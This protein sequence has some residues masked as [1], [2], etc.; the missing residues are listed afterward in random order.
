MEVHQKLIGLHF[1]LAH[2]RERRQRHII[3]RLRADQSHRSRQ[4]RQGLDGRVE[5]DEEDLRHEGH[6]EGARH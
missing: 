5:E 1:S 6:Q 4:L 2:R 3:E